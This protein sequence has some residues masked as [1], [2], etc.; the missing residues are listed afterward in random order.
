V[1]D[2]SFASYDLTTAFGPVTNNLVFGFDGATFSTDQGTFQI[3][4]FSGQGT[5]TA[6]TATPEPASL[7]LPGLGATGL[8]SY[9]RRLKQPRRE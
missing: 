4:I 2:S 9:T 8:L 7:T 1:A 5:F 6:S 3:T